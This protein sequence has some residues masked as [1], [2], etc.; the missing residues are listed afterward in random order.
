[1][2]A[3]AAQR[4]TSDASDSSAGKSPIDC[5]GRRTRVPFSHPGVRQFRFLLRAAAPNLA[6]TRTGPDKRSRGTDRAS[7]S[8]FRGNGPAGNGAARRRAE[9]ARPVQKGRKRN[10][11]TRSAPGDAPAD[12]AQQRI[13]PT[14][15]PDHRL[16]EDLLFLEAWEMGLV[17]WPGALLRVRQIRRANPALAAQVRSGPTPPAAGFAV[18]S[19]APLRPPK[20][21]N[22]PAGG[23]A[24]HER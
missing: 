8:T 11:H 22:A 6:T 16:I 3:L 18:R 15:V 24:G 7:Q 19:P 10:V 4:V 13:P 1:M 14:H 12:T 23:E 17:P 9:Q 5:R 21:A 2:A 20:R